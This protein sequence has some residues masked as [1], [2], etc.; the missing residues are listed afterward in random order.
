VNGSGSK[1]SYRNGGQTTSF[2]Q[3]IY[4]VTVKTSAGAP[5]LIRFSLLGKAVSY[6]LTAA[7]LPLTATFSV[8]PPH[9]TDESVWRDRVLACV[10]LGASGTVKCQ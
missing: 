2:I 5:G 9:A 6:A 1:F 7:D 10:Y 8:D 4:R 3:G